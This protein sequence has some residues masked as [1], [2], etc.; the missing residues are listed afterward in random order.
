[1]NGKS[2]RLNMEVCPR[3]MVIILVKH[4]VNG[5]FFV[6]ERSANKKTFPLYYGIGA[7]GHRELGED[8]LTGAKREL[9]EETGLETSIRYLFTTETFIKDVPQLDYVFET[10]GEWKALPDH[11]EWKSWGW[12]TMQEIDV[13]AADGKLCTDTAENW[14]KYRQLK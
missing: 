10:V 9:H 4:P 11:D 6:H 2:Q 3:E 1:M 12:M 7:G 14:K 8:I 13:L 5:T